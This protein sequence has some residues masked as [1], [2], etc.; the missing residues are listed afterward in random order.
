[1]KQIL[2]IL[3]LTSIFFLNSGFGAIENSTYV[4]TETTLNATP[5]AHKIGLIESERKVV[6]DVPDEVGTESLSEKIGGIVI[7]SISLLVK[8]FFNFMASILN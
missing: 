4:Q 5:K 8:A 3:F 7:T 1:M 6:F 2:S